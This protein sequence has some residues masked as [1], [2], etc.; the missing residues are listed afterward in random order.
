M[1]SVRMGRLWLCVYLGSWGL[2]GV[3]YKIWDIQCVCLET[4]CVGCVCSGIVE[5]VYCG[6]VAQLVGVFWVVPEAPVSLVF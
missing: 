2:W 4:R 1:Y 5:Y 6:A 3:F